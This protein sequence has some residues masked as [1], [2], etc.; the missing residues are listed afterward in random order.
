VDGTLLCRLVL[1]QHGR[2]LSWR[3][4]GDDATN[5]ARM[6]APVKPAVILAVVSQ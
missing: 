6:G 1:N 3:P 5:E 2:L 4:I